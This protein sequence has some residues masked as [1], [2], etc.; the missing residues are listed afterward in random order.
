MSALPPY[1]STFEEQVK[2]Y[3]LVEYYINQCIHATLLECAA[4]QLQPAYSSTAVAVIRNIFREVNTWVKTAI[5]LVNVS[6]S[7]DSTITTK[8]VLVLLRQMAVDIISKKEEMFAIM[9]SVGLC[10]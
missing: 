7:R 8:S 2:W 1:P 5:D 3:A 4:V 10:I 6:E 9:K